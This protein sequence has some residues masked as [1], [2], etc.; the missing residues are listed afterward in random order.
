MRNILIGRRSTGAALLIGT[1]F[2]G[3]LGA[4]SIAGASPV[5]TPP[6]GTVPRTDAAGT[7]WLCRP[8]L[9]A[10]PCA[11][12]QSTTTV[13]ASGPRTV[14]TP[15]TPSDPA[16]DCFYL[17][18]TVSTQPTANA[19]LRIQ[20]V[21]VDAAVAQASPFSQVCRVWA[22]MYRQRTEV[23]LAKG[24]G[25]DPTAD[26]VAFRSVLA[27][28]KDYLANF[29]DGHPV[30]FIGHSQGAAMLIRL[31]AAQVDPSTSLRSRTV[32][33]V[34]AGGNVT[35]PVGRVVGSTFKHLPLCTSTR[36]TGCVIAYSS[37]PTRPPADSDFGR[38][39][40]GVSLQS[41][42][43]GRSGV[44]V[45]CV[46][47]A[48]LGGGTADLDPLF[49][50]VTMSPPAPPVTTP[51]VAYPGLYSATCRSSQGADW[52]QVSDRAAAGDTRPVVT[53]TLGPA[54]GYHLEDLNLALG[55]L[56]GDVALEEQAYTAD[57]G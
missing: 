43:T 11:A 55:N 51:W 30:V 29:N 18:P 15:S 13:P 53:E 52:L 20:A 1:L 8:G 4:T 25:S 7:A 54:W 40:Q 34:I 32:S 35:V 49:P 48:D 5:A 50:S 19:D 23:S 31:L 9:A 24:L 10:D 38:A 47:P 33:A 6:G 37:F 21:E 46:N 3:P 41:G 45:A 12:D 16:F 57:H 2:L 56:V 27:A 26:A 36:E 39:G 28:W 42:Q 14:T 22:P 17:Y 44:Q